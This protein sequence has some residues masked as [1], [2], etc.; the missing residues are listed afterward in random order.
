MAK[1]RKTDKSK[2]RKPIPF[3]DESDES[4]PEP[5]RVVIP[6]SEKSVNY[7]VKEVKEMAEGMN[8]ERLES[9][10]EGDTRKTVQD[11]LN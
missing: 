2:Y 8:R 4:E 3:F 1:Y 7:T 6:D 11:L 5:Y 10:I 9:F